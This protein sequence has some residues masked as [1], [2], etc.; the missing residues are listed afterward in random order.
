[1]EHHVKEDLTGYPRYFWK[2]SINL[3]SKIVK[4]LDLLK[5]GIN[6]ADYFLARAA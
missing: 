5:Y 1:M 4:I 6:V 2:Q 3:F